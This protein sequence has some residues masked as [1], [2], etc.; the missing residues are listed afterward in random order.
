MPHRA[1]RGK[2]SNHTGMI[3]RLEADTDK[4]LR[5]GR[6]IRRKTAEKKDVKARKDT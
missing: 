5:R 1:I 2:K 4:S 6:W 3:R